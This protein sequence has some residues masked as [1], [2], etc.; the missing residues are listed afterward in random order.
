LIH[1]ST[2]EGN[3]MLIRSD[4]SDDLATPIVTIAYIDPSYSES[5]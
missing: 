1:L 5:E 4:L 2:R 3:E